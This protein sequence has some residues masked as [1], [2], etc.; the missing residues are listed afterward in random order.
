MLVIRTFRNT[1]PPFLLKIW[2]KCAAVNSQH[3]RPLSM[4]LLEQHILGRPYF[5][6]NGLFLAFDEN[7]N[8]VGFAH[9]AF[10]PNATHT[11]IDMSVGV[12]CMMMI[13]PEY[14]N[15]STVAN[16]LL[17]ACE[18]YLTKCG[19]KQIY[20]GAVRPAAPFYMGLYGGSEPI[21]VFE[22]DQEIT[23]LYTNS[24][25]QAVHNTLLFR[26]SLESYRPPINVK[27]IMWRRKLSLTCTDLPQPK[28]WWEACMMCNFTWLE[29]HGVLPNDSQPVGIITMR[30]I[31][32][33]EMPDFKPRQSPSLSAPISSYSR[34]VVAGLMDVWVRDDC[35]KQGLATY[36]LGEMLREIQ[37]KECVDIL[38]IQAEEDNQ[39]FIA[40]LKTMQWN[41]A[42]RGTIFLKEIT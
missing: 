37:R 20:G 12:I 31:N 10:G 13:L 33:E 35:R 39:P 29:L 21:G 28:H 9:A 6:R 32:S 42:E 17:Q 22:S 14:E 36:L 34:S 16:T 4:A 1:D 23:K 2:E 11:D 26:V 38:E 24:G 27:T 8:A 40:L 3:F 7:E 30:I 5:D 41:I 19:A 15:D 18:G 25:Y